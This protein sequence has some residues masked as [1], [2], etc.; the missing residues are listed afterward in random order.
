MF[1]NQYDTDV[2]VWS[3]Q[4]RLHQVEY[5]MEA[6]KQ[7]SACLGIRS[8]KHVVLAALKRSPNEMAS[9]Q[10]KLLKVDEH[11]GV[12]IA[13]LMA[14]A[15]TLAKYMRTEALNH[16]YVYGSDMQACR[17]AEDLADMHQRTTQSYV[18]RPYG[19]GMLLAAY[20]QTGPHLFQ[21]CPSGNTF[22][23]YAMAIGARSQSAKTYLEKYQD[24]FE[25]ASLDDLITHGLKALSG[26]MA[27]DKELDASCASI[28]IVGTDRKFT[29]IEGADIQPYLDKIETEGDAG[30]D[31][32]DVGAEETKA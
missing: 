10:D 18:R 19:V 21:T 1:R 4:G 3:P 6:V 22:E 32:M 12:A 31:A 27:G 30:P 23:Y 20:D 5:A 26:C 29:V 9:Y 25:G 8:S 16:K 14:D 15:R 7:G 11:M 13:G 2:T 28:A 24:D 17:L